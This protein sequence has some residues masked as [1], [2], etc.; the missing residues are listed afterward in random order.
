MGYGILLL[1]I[2]IYLF[3]HS[4]WVMIIFLPLLLPYM[5]QWEVQQVS[6]LQSTFELQFRDYL[7]A[8]ASALSAG[9]ALENAMKEARK[10]LGQQYDSTT[11]IM[12]DTGKMERLLEM[13]MSVEQAWIEWTDETEIEVLHQFTTIFMVAKKSGGDSVAIIKKSIH[14]ICER[15]EVEA[16]IKL[17][18][19]AK[20]YEFQIMSVVPIGILCYMKVSFAEFMSILYGNI[21]GRILM[22][23]C[24]ATYAG[25]YVWGKKMLEIEV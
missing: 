14:N 18:L 6:K 23:L 7:Q 20:K 9:Y 2:I 13:N 19:A 3:Y 17:I 8:L 10:D 5:K 21:A 11:R 22:S 12:Q 16:D 24:L 15:L 4:F 25:A 1:M